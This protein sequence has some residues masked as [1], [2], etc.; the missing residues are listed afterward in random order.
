MVCS[1]LNFRL[2]LLVILRDVYT[3]INIK[4]RRDVSIMRFCYTRYTTECQVE[5]MERYMPLVW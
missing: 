4:A 5:H 1:R 3:A 2:R